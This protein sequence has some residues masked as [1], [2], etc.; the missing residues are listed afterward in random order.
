MALLARPGSFRER[1]DTIRRFRLN[2]SNRTPQRGPASADADPPRADHD[3]RSVGTAVRVL[4]RKNSDLGM[5]FPLP[6]FHCPPSS[7]VNSPRSL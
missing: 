5:F 2:P 4:A 1:R 3:G 6:C 7:F